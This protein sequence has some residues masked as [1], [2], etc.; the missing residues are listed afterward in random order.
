MG[1]LISRRQ[2][3][4][5]CA[6][7]VAGGFTGAR[8]V[9]QVR[10]GIF[11][12]TSQG[13]ATLTAYAIPHD[14]RLRMLNGSL[15]RLPAVPDVQ[16]INCQLPNFKPVGV[17]V[18]TRALFESDYAERRTLTMYPKRK[19]VF[20]TEVTIADINDPEKLIPL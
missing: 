13:V 3:I 6:A 1:P 14:R 4:G 15:D 5:T 8:A 2:A 19:N 12:Q 16:V 17:T 20:A 7:A 11:V 18:T 9:A 10:Q